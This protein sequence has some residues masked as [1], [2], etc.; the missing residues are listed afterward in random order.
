[1]QAGTVAAGSR[2]RLTRGA[3]LSTR[4]SFLRKGALA[5]GAVAASTT[6][7]KVAARATGANAPSSLRGMN[8]ILFLTDQERAIQH[9][10]PGWAKDNLPGLTALQRNG[11]TFSHAYTNSCMCSPA[12]STMMSGYMPAQHGVKYTLETDMPSPQYPQVPLPTPPAMA[13]LAT[14]ASA[15]GYN[16]VYKG[17]WH[18]SKPAAADFVWTPQDLALYGWSRWN[19]Q[20]AGANQDIP[21]MGGGL[22]NNDGRF[23]TSVGDYQDSSEGVLQFITKVAAQM[24]PFFLVVSLVNP[25]DVLGYP[26]KHGQAGYSANWLEGDVELPATVDESLDTKPAA[27]KQFLRISQLLGVLRNDQQKRNYL[28]F[29]AN[30]IK[31][32]DQYLLDTLAAL[33][34]VPTQGGTSNLWKDTMVVRSA[35][36]GEMGLA[37]GGMRQKNFNMY[38]EATR[39]PLV[40]SN[41]VLWKRGRTNGAL[42]SHVDLVPTMATLFGTPAAGRAD[43]QGVDYSPIVLGASPRPVQDYVIFTYDD[44]QA[45]QDTGPYVKP[46]Q[47]LVGIREKRWKICLYYDANGTVPG[48]W[49]M[50]DLQSDPEERVNLAYRGHHRTPQQERQLRRLQAKL[51]TVWNTRLQPLSG[52]P[53]PFPVAV[54]PVNVR[55]EGPTKTVS[56]NGNVITDKGTVTG[57]PI[58][59]GD[60]TMVF[61]LN[62]LTSVATCEYTITNPQGTINGTIDSRFT[63]NG[64]TLRFIGTSRFTGGTGAYAGIYSNAPMEYRDTHTLTGQKGAVAFVGSAAL[65]ATPSAQV[66]S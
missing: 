62:P 1:M 29:Y 8:V 36:H 17:K 16:V 20:D 37:H 19:P 64:P 6:A 52:P 4:R 46:P 2:I 11:L 22:A 26:S 13:N 31:A 35:D 5:A 57:S 9:F 60:I 66:V 61:T 24:Q 21:E 56:T 53:V 65:P 7:G 28:N 33:K 38:E 10:P 34:S 63:R 59:S 30:L 27:Q 15:A 43:W 12:R 3:A 54:G 18:C 42:V 58:G 45:G 14:I 51:V 32:S 44:F 39:V 49:E 23:M 48:Q 47:H 41:P 50:Y 55:L 25:H 40:F